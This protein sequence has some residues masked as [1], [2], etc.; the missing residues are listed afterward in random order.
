MEPI[1][2]EQTEIGIHLIVSMTV[3][4]LEGVRARFTLLSL[5]L[6][7]VSFSIRFATPPK[8]A[9]I[10][11]FMRSVAFDTLGSLNIAEQSCI[12]PLPAIFALRDTRIH[13]GTP[14]GSDVLSNIEVSVDET[15]NLT[16]TL[17]IPDVKPYD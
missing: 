2:P 13:I 10:F 16:P 4:A 9:M 7:G 8:L 1:L 5:K 15:F 12:S 3:G 17:D 14:N 11:G 6:R